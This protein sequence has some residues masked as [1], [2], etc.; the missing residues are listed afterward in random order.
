MERLVHDFIFQEKKLGVVTALRE[1]VDA[2]YPILGI[3]TIQECKQI[4]CQQLMRG[5]RVAGSHIMLGGYL[6][7]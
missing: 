1:C 4:F 5:N 7:T 6:Y 3:E 2:I